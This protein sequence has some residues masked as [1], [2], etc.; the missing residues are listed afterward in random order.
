MAEASNKIK[1][2]RP[3]KEGPYG[4]VFFQWQ[5]PEYM[6]HVRSTRWYIVMVALAV[7]LIIYSIFTA[8][9]L[10]A[11]VII[12]IVFIVFLKSYAPPRILDFQITDEGLVLGNQFY[13]Y[14]KIKSFY[15]IYKPPAVKKVFFD[16]KGFSPS[17]SIWLDDMSPLPIREKLLEHLEEDLEKERQSTDDILETLLKL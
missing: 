13:A 9:F 5:I 12:L 7:I 3:Q 17:L 1:D 6:E 8:N 15:V 10:F 14:S 4:Q 16:L 11:L 2:S